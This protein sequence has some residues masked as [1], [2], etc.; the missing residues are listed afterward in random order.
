M[1][2]HT[3]QDGLCVLR[4]DA[5]P[6]NV[7][8]PAM[9]E[10]LREA[11]RRAT[12]DAAVR[13]IVL[14]GGPE[15]FSAGADV[16]LF[17]EIKTAEEAIHISRVFQEAFQAVEDCP[18]AVVA[19]MAG[20]VFGG[21]IELAAACHWRV[22][23]PTCRFRMSEVT[24]GVTPGAGGTQRLPRLVGVEA[25]LEMLLTAET[26][27]AKRAL[28]LGL[29]DA[30][31]DSGGTA[32]RLSH[33]T[34]MAIAD[35]ARSL[36]ENG[37]A[38]R[39]TSMRTDKLHRVPSPCGRVVG[40]EGPHP[41]PLPEGEGTK[42]NSAPEGE[43][44]ITAAGFAWAEKMLSGVR[45]ELIAPR[46]I[47]E[48]VRIGLEESVAAGMRKEQEVFAEC[49][50]T[51]AAQNKIRLFFATRQTSKLAELEGVEPKPAMKPASQTLSAAVVGLGTMGSGIAQAVVAAGLP[52]V[53]LDQNPAALVRGIE[54]IR[55]SIQRRAAQGKIS[56]EQAEATLARMTAAGGWEDLAGVDVV[57]ESVFEDIAT[58]QAVF[59]RLEGVCRLDALLA[60][61][62]STIALD[63]LAAGMKR[64]ERLVGLH[65]F[66]PAQ[67]MPLVE[68]VRGRSTPPEILAAAVN[69]AKHLRKTP[70]V[71]QSR[72]G[73]LVTRVFVPYLQ[74]AFWLLEEGAAAAEIDTA[75]VE[76]GF[77]M[78][79]LQLIDMSGLD[80]LVSAH[81][82]LAAA[83]AWHGPLSAVVA[84]LVQGGH[85]GQKSGAGVFRYDFAGQT[86]REAPAT[87]E[88][89][90]EVRRA[91]GRAVRAVSRA[92]I[93]ERL[94]LR[95]AS[96]AFRVLEEGVVRS[97]EDLD[98]A[99]VLGIGFPDF[100]GGPI[101]YAED[102][103]LDR[104]GRRLAELA[105]QHGGRF[106]PCG[107]LRNR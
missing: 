32:L 64:P 23:T 61:N 22:A 58:K 90:A 75:A 30:V 72:E 91:A 31:C 49:L 37:A 19:A 71:V 86:P 83:L 105:E 103:G 34:A 62:T 69:L 1:I 5:P 80:I 104:V 68:V 18:K 59:E 81:R 12:E 94:T 67:T 98:V 28:E 85:L 57:I 46:R 79:P 60:T 53:V 26:V 77:P 54:R 51:T 99:M 13:G 36:L 33:P 11:L 74:E 2:D 82:V 40:G 97:A 73:F 50:G 78:G 15:H 35:A 10:E 95:M 17:R 102:L 107:L 70:V 7:I 29:V 3:L 8:T 84:G 63:A 55:G 92:E 106:E 41:N 39:K 24:L 45:P 89:V 43:G 47:V 65:F 6:L 21:G 101:R 66:H 42:I 87:V 56:P 20:T 48:A 96:E 9:L 100:R 76:F 4:L 88:I 52:V 16:N 93:V 14:T 25:A 27:D 38:P 44:T